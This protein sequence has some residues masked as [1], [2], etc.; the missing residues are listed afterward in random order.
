VPYLCPTMARRLSTLSSTS[1]VAG[2]PS[3]SPG[4]RRLARQQIHAGALALYEDRLGQRGRLTPSGLGHQDD[5][6]LR[7]STTAGDAA[8]NFTF[9]LQ[10]DVAVVTGDWDGNGTDTPGTVRDEDGTLSWRTS[11]APVIWQQ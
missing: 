10:T 4:T 3:R 8:L 7:N 1:L 9:G 11:D 6:L 5:L 2:P